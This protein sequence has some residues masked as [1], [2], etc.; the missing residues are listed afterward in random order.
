MAK[1]MVECVRV[2]PATRREGARFKRLMAA[3]HYLKW[4]KPVGE[5]L[6]YVAEVEGRWVALLV[7][8]AAA[9]ALRDRDAWIGWEL[10]QRCARLNFI[11]QNRR[12][13]ILPGVQE[14]NL[15]SRILGLCTQRLAADWEAAY[16][17]PV[18]SLET[19]VD[20]Q[21]FE[22]TCYRAAGWIA[23]GLTAGLRRVRRDF[24]DESG[25][26]KQLLVKPLTR[27]ACE[28]L[29]A[30]TWPETWR[31]H[32]RVVGPRDILRG[33]DHCS[34]FRAYLAVPEFRSAHGRRHCMASVLACAT[35]A[36]LAG[37]EGIGE[38]AEF[39]AGLQG[40]Y[41]RSLGCPYDR[42]SKRFLAPSESTL[43]RVLGGVDAV[44]V[45][46][47]LG[48]WVRAR[49][50]VAAVAIDGKTLKAS[51]DRTGRRNTLVAAVAHGS[52]APLAQLAVP[53]GTNETATA[54]VLLDVLPPL[55]GALVSLDAAHTNAE[56]ARKVVIRKGADYL[57]PVKGNQ[58]GLLDHAQRLLPQASFSP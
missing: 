30:K 16:G 22:G 6:S 28:R 13:L 32:E 18:L 4:G 27:D 38:M 46:A 45:D 20:P 12:F 35:C 3:H 55:D 15:A 2:R 34:L 14:P 9:Y 11:A 50:H 31:S 37:V 5:T 40:R 49:E 43:R 44:C 57:L 19:F 7:F 21:R 25:S 8:G 36:T 41:L 29:C 54:R 33:Q 24:Y 42:Q 39:V 17:H 58:P 51:L 10:P 47:V 52:G 26:P 1:S 23:L 53:A 56:T 48:A